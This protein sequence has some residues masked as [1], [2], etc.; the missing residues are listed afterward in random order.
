MSVGRIKEDH[1]KKKHICKVIDII[2]NTRVADDLKKDAGLKDFFNELLKNYI[3]EKYKLELTGCKFYD[4]CNY[5]FIRIQNI[6]NE[7]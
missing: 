1:D 6:E 7:I 5:D 3:F 4:N 2:I